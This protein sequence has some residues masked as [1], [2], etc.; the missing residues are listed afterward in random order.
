MA[1][2]N[3]A[4]RQGQQ[5]LPLHVII[6]RS[7]LLNAN[8]ETI[9]QVVRQDLE[10]NNDFFSHIKDSSH[11]SLDATNPGDADIDNLYERFRDNL[12][13]KMQGDGPDWM[14][15][16]DDKK[17]HFASEESIFQDA[18]SHINRMQLSPEHHD[19]AIV[20]L[21]NTDHHGFLTDT[22]R[23]YDYVARSINGV[24]IEEIA[25]VHEQLKQLLEPVGLLAKDV[26]ESL[27]LQIDKHPR[28]PTQLATRRIVAMDY[29]SF[30]N[31]D[32]DTISATLNLAT[33]K[34][35]MWE[36]LEDCYK[37][38]RQNLKPFPI[39]NNTEAVISS[40]RNPDFIIQKQEDGTYKAKATKDITPKLIMNED[41]FR[42]YKKL[43]TR[44]DSSPTELQWYEDQ[45]TKFKE[46]EKDLIA[47]HT[48]AEKLIT[49]LVNEQKA[50]IES[51]N[52]DDI[53]P[54]QANKVAEL[55][56]I[57]AQ[58]VGRAAS[59]KI[60][61]DE[62]GSVIRL[63]ELFNLGFESKDS[64]IS[65]G[66]AK[67]I[68]LEA[69]KTETQEA[70]FS[71]MTLKEYFQR[72]EIIIG[73]TSIS[74]LRQEMEIPDSKERAQSYRYA[75][76]QEMF[77]AWGIESRGKTQIVATKDLNEIVLSLIKEEDRNRPVT[78]LQIEK[79]LKME[80]ITV[81]PTQVEKIRNTLRIPEYK[82]RQQEY[83]DQ[84][85]GNELKR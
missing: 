71:D 62:Q 54:M 39:L 43:K 22:E 33:D 34:Q 82:K 29:H 18:E 55:F 15:T 5:Q 78:D 76:Q 6:R 53:I 84:P 25:S 83:Q 58:T 81:S 44:P 30:I 35:S 24:T 65:R 9:D 40:K 27:L 19:V 48:Y 69:I 38:A 23:I 73:L 3:T 49:Y 47:R 21:Y 11:E 63:K 79:R 13:V 10:L 37:F 61:V 31:R 77:A 80:G 85:S 2:F 12:G 74:M 1:S 4:I 59:N 26:Q 67:A 28:T 8:S 70:P 42:R 45:Y 7:R 46:Y 36:V 60:T 14:N 57:T 56:G 17:G 66:E 50:F 51:A 68:V 16:P 20:L 72:K 75:G 41:I 32:F 64:R 52:T